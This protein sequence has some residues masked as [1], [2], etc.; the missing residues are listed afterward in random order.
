MAFA[1]EIDD[2]LGERVEV[3]L[4]CRALFA[5]GSERVRDLG[6]VA[7]GGLGQAG[8]LQHRYQRPPKRRLL[9]VLERAQRPCELRRLPSCR[10]RARRTADASAWFGGARGSAPPVVTVMT[11]EGGMRVGVAHRVIP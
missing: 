9:G 7:A 11:S 1:G 6:G 4:R 8:R 2:L 10:F 3:S 5:G